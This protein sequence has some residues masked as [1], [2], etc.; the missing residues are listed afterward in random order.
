MR[1]AIFG[2]VLLAL[3][4]LV[5]AT[6]TATEVP[7]TDC[8]VFP[9]NNIWNTRVDSLPVHDMSETWLASAGA[10]SAGLHPD[11]GPP[12]YGIPF[13]VVGR[14]HDDVEVD[15]LYANESDTGPYPFDARTSI[16]GGSDHHAL[17]VERGTCRLYELFDASWNDGDPKAGSGAIFDLDRNRLRPETWTSADAAGLPILAGLVRW[18]EVKAGN[19][20]HAI[21]FTVDCTTEAYLWPA[22]HEA[23]VSDPDCPPMGARFRLRAGFDLSGFGA[24]ARTIL[25]AMQRYGL[26]LADN[27]S[28]WYFQGRVDDHWT[29][30]LLDQLKTVPASAFEAVDVSACMVDVDSGRA[31]CP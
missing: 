29:N 14:G 4:V 22:R 6:A 25:L 10:G 1:R 12:D 8:A 9:A 28:N 19:I 27:G 13:D 23:G 30:R 20:R 2:P 26:M 16:E 3:A 24:K 5:P 15:F 18:D 7:G 31:D 21:R 17:I 11:F